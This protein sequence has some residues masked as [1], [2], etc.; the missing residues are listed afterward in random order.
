MKKAMGLIVFLFLIVLT[1]KTSDAVP[2]PMP[3]ASPAAELKKVEYVLPY[4]GILPDHLLYPVKMFRDKIML[5][6][7]SDKQK[8]AEVYLLL[9]DK[10]LGAGKVLID[11]GKNKLGVET[12][13]K[14]EKY[15]EQ[16]VL[17]SKAFKME[18]LEGAVQKHLEV[19]EEI[20]V[21]TSATDKQELLKAQ[22]L[23]ISLQQQILEKK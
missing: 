23:T 3:T 20:M 14:A 5:L 12:L 19:L 18:K 4:P 8:K 15:L 17:E 1:V 2:L 21:K 22:A 16:A 10:R 13:S 9:A 6:L 11:G 7:I